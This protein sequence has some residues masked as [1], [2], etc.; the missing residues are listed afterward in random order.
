MHFI[1]PY[2][3]PPPHHLLLLM[4][5]IG[6]SA[7]LLAYCKDVVPADCVVTGARPAAWWTCNGT[8]MMIDRQPQSALPFRE[9]CHIPWKRT[10][11]R[12][13]TWEKELCQFQGVY[14]SA[15][16]YIAVGSATVEVTLRCTWHHP[17]S[18]VRRRS[19]RFT[20]RGGLCRPAHE[21]AVVHWWQ[22]GGEAS[23]KTER[24][25]AGIRGGKSSRWLGMPCRFHQRIEAF[26]AIK[27]CVLDEMID[28][29]IIFASL[30]QRIS[31][32]L[33]H[34][35]AFFSECGMFWGN[36]WKSFIK[37]SGWVS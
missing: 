2:P 36:L 34:P 1:S 25:L 12:K 11:I 33:F 7:L 8:G 30:F 16:F 27:R 37:P 3:L 10:I 23:Y 26:A 29:L 18:R 5:Y 24:A 14:F 15:C 31:F 13:T 4:R 9:R 20:V 17:E 19:W 35:F 28:L 32:G 6:I 22:E 21:F